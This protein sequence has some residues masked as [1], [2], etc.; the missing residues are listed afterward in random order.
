[1]QL[2]TTTTVIISILVGSVCPALISL[3]L[4]RRKTI[5]FGSAIYNLLG[6]ALLQKRA[7]NLPIPANALGNLMVT[8]RAT[9]ADLAFGVY[10]A[11]RKDW[12]KEERQEKIEEYV[13]A[14]GTATND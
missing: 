8:I 5:G 6:A 12:T 7:Q 1:M 2:D 3:L 14:M 9:L 13:Q 10:A 4:P 11:S